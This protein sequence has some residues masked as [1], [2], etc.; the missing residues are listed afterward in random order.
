MI[1]L[2]GILYQEN[3]S[4]ALMTSDIKG[5][6][7]TS[8]LIN[9]DL[10]AEINQTDGKP[11]Y[12]LYTSVTKPSQKSNLMPSPIVSY[13]DVT[14]DVKD[15]I[16]GGQGKSSFAVPGG[17]V[18][19]VHNASKIEFISSCDVSSFSPGDIVI[20]EKSTFA[21]A[22]VRAAIV[23]KTKNESNILYLTTDNL[24]GIAA[25]DFIQKYSLFSY[26]ISVA[27]NSLKALPGI[28]DQ[29][30][31]PFPPSSFNVTVLNSTQVRVSWTKPE[32]SNASCYHVYYAAGLNNP[33]Y[34]SNMTPA[35]GSGVNATGFTIT[36]LTSGAKY[37]F[38]AVSRNN[39]DT[40][41]YLESPFSNPVSIVMS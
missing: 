6:Y 12:L 38:A 17:K 28:L 18:G 13:R 16:Y 4:T 2:S 37:T 33:D 39:N 26:P 24:T 10:K 40:N 36:G 41:R 34:S 11:K 30:E 9:V 19:T 35:S 32:C 25:G 21:V 29:L 27:R 14:G 31:M 20:W 5:A 22:D 1:S 3:A 8:D 15:C 7:K 23:D